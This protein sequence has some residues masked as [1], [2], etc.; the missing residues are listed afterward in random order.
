MLPL[1]LRLAPDTVPN[2]RFNVAKTLST[3][4]PLLDGT[5]V[6]QKVRPCLSKLFDDTDRDVKFYASQALQ[7]C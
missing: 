4:I 5:V 2:I 1:L 3:L 7:L 6:Q